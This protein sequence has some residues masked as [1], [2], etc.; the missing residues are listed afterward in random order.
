MNP[1]LH[2]NKIF[3]IIDEETIDF[4]K[5]AVREQ[6]SGAESHPYEPLHGTKRYTRVLSSPDDRI[7]YEVTTRFSERTMIQVDVRR[8]ETESEVTPIGFAMGGTIPA[9]VDCNLLLL[10]L[11]KRNIISDRREPISIPLLRDQ[12]ESRAWDNYIA[13]ACDPRNWNPQVHA[14]NYSPEVRDAASRITTSAQLGDSSFVLQCDYIAQVIR[15]SGKTIVLCR[16]VPVCT[17]GIMSE[18]WYFGMREA[19]YLLMFIKRILVEN[20]PSK[21]PATFKSIVRYR[22][23]IIDRLAFI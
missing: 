6:V 9:L 3:R 1:T 20:A 15:K 14:L 12:K 19:I 8:S 4:R 11:E 2:V 22:E 13:W 23:L 21:V 5:G 16:F 18:S 10:E 7:C 17:A